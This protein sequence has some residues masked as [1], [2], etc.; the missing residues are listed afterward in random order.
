MEEEIT[1]YNLAVFRDSHAAITETFK[2]LSDV[3]YAPSAAAAVALRRREDELLFILCGAVQF[4]LCFWLPYIRDPTMRKAYATATGIFCCLYQ[5]GGTFFL[6]VL[7]DVLCWAQLRFLPVKAGV[8]LTTFV[9]LGLLVTYSAWHTFNGTH[10]GFSVKTCLMGTF[11]R[12]H[13]TAINYLDAHK[14]AAEKAEKGKKVDLTSRERYFAEGMLEPPSFANWMNYHLSVVASCCGMAVEYRTYKEWINLEGKFKEMRPGSHVVPALMRFGETLLFVLATLSMTFIVKVKYMLTPEFALEPL[15]YRVFFLI[16]SMHIRITTMFVGFK[17][18]ESF[19]VASGEGYHCE[20]AEDGKTKIEK[21]DYIRAGFF[22]KFEASTS[23]TESTQ[24]WNMQAHNWLKYYVML[25]MLDRSKPKNA[26]QPV[27]LA[28]AYFASLAWHGIDAGY[29][30]FF[31]GL[32]LND[33]LSR[34][35]SR[36]TIAAGLRS[37]LHP[38][39]AYFFCWLWNIFCLSYIGMAFVFVQYAKF[40]IMHAAFGHFMHYGLPIGILLCS[41]LPKE[42]RP[43][44]TSQTEV[45]NAPATPAG[46]AKSE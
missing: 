35:F 21:Y 12:V 10:S 9:S 11:L 46:K 17:Y 2:P 14:L 3:V 15:W 8:Y 22:R 25:R 30:F 18:M 7:Y 32:G 36:T 29:W 31:I 28:V 26:I 24:N 27:P 4:F 1:K 43:K 16:A 40:D 19:I 5:F 23:G 13:M 44:K 6:V 38:S 42:R 34:L 39:V 33:L 45:K 20:V 41:V 37:V